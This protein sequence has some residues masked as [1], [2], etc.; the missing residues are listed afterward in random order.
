MKTTIN[1]PADFFRPCSI[2]IT[3][4]TQ[5]ELDSFGTLCNNG[6]IL[7]A[8]AKTGGKLPS[9]DLMRELGAN[10]KNVEAQLKHFVNTVYITNLR[11]NI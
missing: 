2:T 7:E 9:Y 5:E 11:N 10:I 6:P 3:F 4:E 8:L 1:K